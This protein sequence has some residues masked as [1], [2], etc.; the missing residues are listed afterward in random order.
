MNVMI[1]Q[2]NDMT[3]LYTEDIDLRNDTKTGEKRNT[4]VEYY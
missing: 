1:S 4:I 3:L 2:V